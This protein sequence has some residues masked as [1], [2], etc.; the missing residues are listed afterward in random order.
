VDGKQPVDND[1]LYRYNKGTVNTN[2]QFKKK[3]LGII[4]MLGFDF[5]VNVS[6]SWRTSVRFKTHENKL[7]LE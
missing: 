6:N 5:E 2:L 4:S 7:R 3:I 1:K